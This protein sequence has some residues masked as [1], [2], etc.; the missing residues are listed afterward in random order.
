MNKK[1]WEY[2]N[3][4]GITRYELT[5]RMGVTTG[6]MEKYFSGKKSTETMTLKSAVK[7]AEVLGVSPEDILNAK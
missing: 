3:R 1:L 2:L 5:K 7:M 6:S 4:K